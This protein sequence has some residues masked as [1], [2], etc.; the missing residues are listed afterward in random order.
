MKHRPTHYEILNVRR[1]ASPEVIR[2]AY[3]AL[4]QKYHPDR[5][6]SPDAARI[7]KE[8]NLAY[9][10]LSDPVRRRQYDDTLSDEEPIRQTSIDP[11]S[12]E[13]YCSTD[14]CKE[15]VVHSNTW[16]TAITSRPRK[17]QYL[18]TTVEH[19]PTLHKYRCPAC[20]SVRFFSDEDGALT[21]VSGLVALKRGVE[22][23]NAVTTAIFGDPNDPA[24]IERRKRSDRRF[25]IFI[26]VAAMNSYFKTAQRH[27][28]QQ[29]MQVTIPS[30]GRL[31]L[32]MRR[33]VPHL[34]WC[35]CRVDGLGSSGQAP[36][37]IGAHR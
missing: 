23:F 35:A 1:D 36:V 10:V 30:I 29:D 2:A 17:M 16:P 33:M 21:D 7:M 6:S 32:K 9:E 25:R 12:L 37:C 22:A 11:G 18:G 28:S 31:Y 20:E 5:N 4:A 24:V 26:I 15:A 19:G 13:V 27:F 34:I 8:V 3:K 14:K